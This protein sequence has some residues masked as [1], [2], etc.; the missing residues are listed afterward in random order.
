ML[1]S[2][3]VH[4]IEYEAMPSSHRRKRDR[5]PTAATVRRI[6]G[7][8]LLGAVAAMI[9]V[10]TLVPFGDSRQGVCAACADAPAIDVLMNI[11]LFGAVGAGLALIGATMRRGLIIAA[12]FATSIEVLQLVLPL[13]R[14]ASL[15]DLFAALAGAALGFVTV[16]N[17]RAILYPRSARS[18]RF[19]GMAT[20]TW[21][22]VLLATGWGFQPAGLRAPYAGE[23]TP[24]VDGL[25]RH[26][27]RV[28]DAHLSGIALPNGPVAQPAE[29]DRA[30]AD[31]L[32]LDLSVEPGVPTY[33]LAP[34]IRA[35]GRS[36]RE[37]L[38]LGR[39]GDDLVYRAGINAQSLG[40]ST[41][42]LILAGA[43]VGLDRT[44]T[45]A[46]ELSAE[47]GPTG[48]RVSGYGR[49][50]SLPFHPAAGW[51]LFWPGRAIP[52]ASFDLIST[53]WVLAPLF[54]IAY[55][56][57]RR[58]RRRARRAGD[59]YRMTGTAGEIV[60]ALPVL[61]LA[62]GIGLAGVAKAFGLALPPP[63]VWVGAAIGIA[64]GLGVGVTRAL[65]HSDRAHSST[66]VSSLPNVEI[67]R[68][69]ATGA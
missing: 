65:A 17:R 2:S 41:P 8:L 24:H 39:R 55:W 18:L 53:L 63:L 28:I 26:T 33:N 6:E 58:A 23:W 40:L 35:T 31:G 67:T 36:K 47:H 16:V 10:V 32:R 49:A 14:G 5:R 46:A 7:A 29:L 25:T 57:G 37:I 59:S 1:A 62:V 34:I 27:G 22:L 20:G 11:L 60:R 44:S 38:M 50:A 19:A 21:L 9:V 48:L 45:E 54:V 13:Q 4:A 51:M 56:V 12:I 66:R 69:A 30:I 3:L 42:A 61:A 43:F 52:Q 15:A 64:L 68:P